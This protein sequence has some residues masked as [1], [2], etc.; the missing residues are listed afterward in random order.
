MRLERVF[1]VHVR[2][3]AE[4][5]PLGSLAGIFLY[6]QE[7][8]DEQS[9]GV[10]ADSPLLGNLVSLEL[11]HM[12]PAGVVKL[13]QSPHLTRLRRLELLGN[14]LRNRD[15][16]ALLDSM[17]HLDHLT[18]LCLTGNFFGDVVLQALANEPRLANLISLRFVQTPTITDTGIIALAASPYLANLT[19]L[20]LDHARITEEGARALLLSP[21]LGN[22]TYLRGPAQSES[23]TK[24]T[25]DALRDRFGS[26]L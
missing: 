11:C 13:L 20:H 15:A 14:G 3:L 1:A 5:P 10:L 19:T 6:C 18:E 8:I 22:V 12:G 26:S 21:Y 9:A 7:L 24:A 16:L 23:V 25:K 17:P 4:C 2:R